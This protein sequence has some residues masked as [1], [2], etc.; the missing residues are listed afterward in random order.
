[1]DDLPPE[2]KF[3]F[4]CLLKLLHQQKPYNRPNAEETRQVASRLQAFKIAR[5][6]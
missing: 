2:L 6:S 3:N 1:M 4:N 5:L